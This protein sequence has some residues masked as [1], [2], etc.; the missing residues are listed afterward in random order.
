MSTA[1]LHSADTIRR[2]RHAQLVELA[3]D[4]TAT[5]VIGHDRIDAAAIHSRPTVLRRVAARLAEHFAPGIDRLLAVTSDAP[6]ATAV[7]LHSG[8]PFATIDSLTFDADCT[9]TVR[10]E[11]H[12]GE[13]VA[14]VSTTTLDRAVQL[15]E[16]LADR[17]IRVI[18]VVSAIA[19][20]GDGNRC[21]YRLSADGLE[22]SHE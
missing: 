16:Y 17:Q 13:D 11:L 8:I 22:P 7:S 4:L 14:I 12:P 9:V 5:A 10:G 3:A 21:L 19:A 15:R 1:V 2:S 6:L 20:P 18:A